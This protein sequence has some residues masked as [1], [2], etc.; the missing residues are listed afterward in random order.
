MSSTFEKYLPW[1]LGAAGVYF[2]FL[3]PKTGSGALPV[4]P[5]Y[6]TGQLQTVQPV[7]ST[8]GTIAT[9]LLSLVPVVTKLLGGGATAAPVTT[10]VASNAPAY[11]GEQDEIDDI[12]NTPDLPTF[13]PISF[14]H[15]VA[16]PTPSAS[17]F[18]QSQPGNA[19]GK[20]MANLIGNEDEDEEY[21]LQTFY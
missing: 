12:F 1:A 19:S 15:I 14:N 3:R 2:V 17:N 9:G 6:N 21:G 5:V 16:T 8:A 7:S 10:P 20:F 18:M 13:A 11:T 4:S